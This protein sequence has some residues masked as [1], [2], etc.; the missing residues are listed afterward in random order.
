MAGIN[1]ELRE[2]DQK[3][4]AQRRLESWKE[5]AA[6]L[7]RSVRTV[8]RWERLEGLPVYRHDHSKQATVY[9]YAPELD[10]WLTSRT[11]VPQDAPA[12]TEAPRPGLLSYRLLR[13]W[14]FLTA[15]LGLALLS[16]IL[17]GIAFRNWTFV[18]RL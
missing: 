13:V 1:I 9:S 17:Y 11:A 18:I 10:A 4:S 8:R 12:A 7:K 14:F 3:A 6:Y 5:I 2:N 15:G 16:L